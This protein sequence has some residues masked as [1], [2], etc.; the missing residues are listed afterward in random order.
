L[1]YREEM[2]IFKTLQRR[3]EVDRF[4]PFFHHKEP[5]MKLQLISIFVLIF[6]FVGCGTSQQTESPS[7]QPELISMTSLP[8]V[9]P[10]FPTNGL[11]INVLF[12][13]NSDGSV[14]EVRM[15]GS[16]GDPAWDRSA[17][18]SMRQWRFAPYQVSGS[19]SSRWIRNTIILQVQ[20][21]TILTLGELTAATPQ[22]ADSLYSL[23]RGGMDFDTLAKQVVAGTSTMVGKFLGVVD[24]AR[25]PK[26]VRDELRKLALN[27]ITPPLRIGAK[28]K[29]YKRYMPDGPVDMP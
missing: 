25:Y 13:A 12:H 24:I 26:H 8:P 11:K 4:F 6:L 10:G 18:D 20:E 17:V 1:N 15:L 14:T 27:E 7:D 28:Y 9:A 3:V 22:E 21:P 29:I 16:S 19:P 23:L 2:I 5:S